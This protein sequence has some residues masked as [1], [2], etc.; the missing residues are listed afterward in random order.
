MHPVRT[1]TGGTS[2]YS[3]LLQ[4]CLILFLAFASSAVRVAE[5]RQC[6]TFPFPSELQPAINPYTSIQPTSSYRC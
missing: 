2:C 6:L 3:R 5:V 1:L 4:D